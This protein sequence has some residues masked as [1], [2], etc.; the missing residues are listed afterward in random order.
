M[1]IV[2]TL[3]T[4]SS[5]WLVLLPVFQLSTAWLSVLCLIGGSVLGSLPG[6]N[7][8]MW[9]SGGLM[10]GTHMFSSVLQRRGSLVTP[11]CT[12][13][14]PRPCSP[15]GSALCQF[16]SLGSYWFGCLVSLMLPLLVALL[17]PHQPV[18]CTCGL[19]GL[20]TLCCTSLLAFLSCFWGV[21]LL[22]VS[23]VGLHLG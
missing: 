1:P 10:R 18:G 21:G 5:W 6:A 22:L 12:S 7:A 3:S 4:T 20:A 9:F 14:T 17:F 23:G 19:T 15:V 8:T 2:P 13:V 11:L 16:L